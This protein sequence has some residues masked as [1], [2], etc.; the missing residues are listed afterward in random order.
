[1]RWQ[2][3]LAAG[4]ASL[5]ACG[6]CLAWS[7][8]EWTYRPPDDRVPVAT[9][10]PTIARGQHL[11]VAIAVC[12]V[13]HGDDLAGKLA[14]DDPFLGH[15]YTANLTAGRGG[16]GSRYETSDWVRSIRYGV[17]PDGTAINFMPS[18]HY[19]AITDTDLG[20]MISFLRRLPPVDNERTRV[21]LNPV[22]RLLIAIGLFGEVNRT[23][24]IDFARP[25]QTSPADPAAYLIDIAGCTFCHGPRLKGARG[26]EPGAPI[27]PDLTSTGLRHDATQ[28][29]FVQSLR[30][31]I[32]GDGHPIQPKYMPW[33]GYRN[34]TDPELLSIWLYL[35]RAD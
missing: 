32:A 22:A 1:M 11:V 14:F 31:G 18:D 30:S 29:A 15:G 16:I 28:S 6:I 9:D 5:V 8:S 25:R 12:T 33:A 23:G 10:P 34:M 27:A 4:S 19:N 17:R 35:R 7:T 21:E 2:T 13:C 3:W 24:R 20:A 26:P